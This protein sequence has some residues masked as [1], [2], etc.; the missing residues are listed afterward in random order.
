MSDPPKAHVKRIYKIVTNPDTM[1]DGIV[2]DIFVDMLR[3][4]EAPVKFQTA[5]D[6]A[7]GQII[8]YKF[9]W[10]D[11]Q[12]NPV[13]GVDASNAD[14]I[15][16]N[17]NASRKTEKRRI[18]DPGVATDSTPLPTGSSDSSTSV[19]DNDI[20]LWIVDR[21]KIAMPQGDGT[22]RQGQV[23]QFVFNNLPLDGSKGNPAK[24]KTSP[25]KIVNNDLNGLK[26]A[27]ADNKPLPVDWVDYKQALQ[28]GK[29]DP[30]D[31]LFLTVECVEQFTV[32]FG[33]NVKIGT[34]DQHV[35]HVL[36]ENTKN[37]EPLFEAGDPDVVDVNGKSA[38]IRTD[39]LQFIVN[40][41]SNIIAVQFAAGDT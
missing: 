34:L 30:A 2:T 23:V 17:A 33:A 41:G 32:K 1:E 25:I 14:L 15:Y 6:G 11:D 38:L 19:D 39:P 40:V 16:E 10:N 35:I 12:N 28:D 4:E 24:R 31:K 21:L 22:G 5:D 8:R 27:D 18:S 26:M 37:V 13:D 3:I 36:T 29:T 7:V 20:Y 9:I